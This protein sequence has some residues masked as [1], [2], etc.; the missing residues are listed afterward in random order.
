MALTR[1]LLGGDHRFRSGTEAAQVT[2]AGI[3]EGLRPCFKWE[4]KPE[5]RH[6]KV[7]QC[8]HF[9][10][11]P[12]VY[13]DLNRFSISSV[14]SL[15]K[16][17][18]CCLL[19]TCT[20]LSNNIK[21]NTPILIHDQI[22]MITELAPLLWPCLLNPATPHLLLIT[23]PALMT[24]LCLPR[25]LCIHSVLHLIHFPVASSTVSPCSFFMLHIGD[26]LSALE[27]NVAVILL[28]LRHSWWI[29]F[30]TWTNW[31]FKTRCFTCGWAWL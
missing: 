28:A 14:G 6:V 2:M 11:L 8:G 13:G 17:C 18:G 12:L 15:E 25:C 21:T 31:T 3:I 27:L 10:C 7:G 19:I 20:S 22:V 24:H 9:A 4:R 16:C 1:P 30:K 23:C 29:S 5:D 26:T